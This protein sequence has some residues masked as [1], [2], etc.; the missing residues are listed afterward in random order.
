MLFASSYITFVERNAA[1]NIIL[2]SRT[3]DSEGN[4]SLTKV[5][6]LEEEKHWMINLQ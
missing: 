1:A 4:F 6:S 3:V 5:R 2:R